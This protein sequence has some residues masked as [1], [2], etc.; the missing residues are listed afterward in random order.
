MSI[1]SLLLLSMVAWLIYHFSRSKG[2]EKEVVLRQLAYGKSIGLF[3]LI[4]GVLGQLI[5]FY[6]AFSAIEQMGQVSPVMVYGGIK[7]SM[8]TTLY[9]M[10]IYLISIMLWFVFSVSVDKRT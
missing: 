5:G 6:S 3:A 1:L 2:V 4:V 10:L 8:I 9:G 7:V